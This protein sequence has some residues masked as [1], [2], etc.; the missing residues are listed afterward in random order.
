MMLLLSFIFL[1]TFINFLLG[2]SLGLASVESRRTKPLLTDGS[3]ERTIVILF[4]KPAGVVTSHFSDDL[5]PT[6][7]DEVKSMKGFLSTKNNS[8]PSSFE[9]TT[10]IR[11][12]LH[13][14]GRLDA[15]TTG[16]LLLTNDGGL[17]HHV[18]NANAPSHTSGAITKTYEALIMGH[19]DEISL[20][21][22]W[23]GIDIGAKYGGITKPVDALKVLKHPNHKSTVVSLTISEGKNRQVRRMF[24]ALGSGVM[25]LKRTHL[26]KH[27]TLEGVEE[28]QWRILSDKE[29][30]QALSWKPRV[31]IDEFR[32]LMR[33][34]G[35]RMRRTPKVSGVNARNRRNRKG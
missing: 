28:G 11:S 29:V 24:H 35:K 32:P 20:D 16:L 30:I 18:T 31:L 1:A 7:Y 6:V 13:A 8:H 15:D 34:R 14:I 22:L 3:T 4:H 2:K 5:R 12:K 25:K 21:A 26:G 23:H 33:K 9:E 17:I 19:H 10:G 27:L